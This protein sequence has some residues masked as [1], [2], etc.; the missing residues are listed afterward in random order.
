MIKAT[1]SPVQVLI[2][3]GLLSGAAVLST[4]AVA[5]EPATPSATEQPGAAAADKAPG[6]AG[7]PGDAAQPGDSAQ[8]GETPPPAIAEGET[9]P[10]PDGSA[11]DSA[12]ADANTG[13]QP[14]VVNP[15]LRDA[16]RDARRGRQGDPGLMG[17]NF[18]KTPEDA[19]FVLGK[20]FGN[21]AVIKDTVLAEK[22]ILTIERIWRLPGGD[23]VNLLLDRAT[24]AANSNNPDLALKLLDAAVEQAP[25]YAEAWS[26]RAFVY[27]LKGEQERALGDLRRTLAL[28]PKHFRALEGLAKILGESGEKKGAYKALQQLLKIHPN[29]SGAKETADELRKA[30]EGQGI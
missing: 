13:A 1:R 17:L 14:D 22:V 30:V 28:E 7:Q 29:A 12:G 11:G 3:A 26:R 9:A 16:Y 8:P 23:T 25:D 2:L 21:L 20:L 24:K 27:Y 6:D 10:K 15:S 5:E 18:P 4:A 19:Q